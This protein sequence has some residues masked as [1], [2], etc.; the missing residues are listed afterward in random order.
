M[1]VVG[2]LATLEQD[3]NTRIILWSLS[4][5]LQSFTQ[6]KTAPEGAIFGFHLYNYDFLRLA[7]PIPAKPSTTSAR[8]EGSGTDEVSATEYSGTAHVFLTAL[9]N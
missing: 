9:H 4:G 6:I 2:R 7:K 3:N 8:I 1:I 5:Q